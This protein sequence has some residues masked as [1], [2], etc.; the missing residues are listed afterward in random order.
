MASL[1]LSTTLFLLTLMFTA[2]RV[3]AG[4]LVPSILASQSANG[5]FLVVVDTEYENSAH[6]GGQNV[7]RCTF[8]VMEALKYQSLNAPITLWFSF[9]EN[10]QVTLDADGG[11]FWPMVSDDGQ[12]LVLIGRALPVPGPSILKIY[13]RNRGSQD[14]KLVRSYQIG[15]LWT[16]RQVTPIDKGL[17]M[18][19]NAP[20][21][22]EKGSFKF[23][24]DSQQLSYRNPWNEDKFIDLRDGSV[25]TTKT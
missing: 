8:P 21:W 20:M 22:F 14:V 24:D 16:P 3:V 19:S 23:T 12:S 15:D 17:L 4:P 11:I 6:D 18:T 13:H 10:W 2:T 5:R 1:R 9:A 7:R 25:S